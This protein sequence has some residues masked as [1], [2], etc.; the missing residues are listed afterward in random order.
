MLAQDLDAADE[1]VETLNQKLENFEKRAKE[2]FYLSKESVLNEIKSILM[3][4]LH[5]VIITTPTIE[6]LRDLD[7]YEV[8]PSVNIKVATWI[9]PSNPD[10]QDILRELTFDNI[11]IRID[12][13]K[14]RYCILSDGAE[15]FLGIEGKNENEI[16]TLRTKDSKHIKFL[17]SLVM[18][19]WLRARKLQNL[20]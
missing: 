8:K 9:D 18:E 16:L 12:D 14:D 17:S 20:D 13:F 2:G 6:N 7:L 11:M 10:H 1:E 15:L 4:G 3:K 5:S 19:S